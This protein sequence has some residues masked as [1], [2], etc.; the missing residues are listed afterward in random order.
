M[1]QTGKPTSPSTPAASFFCLRAQLPLLTPGG[2]IVNA[3]SVFGQIGSPGV[4]AYCASKAAVI[5][6]SR[7]AAKE[8]PSV[9]INCVAPGSVNT[10]MNQGEDPEDVRRGLEKTVMKRSAGAEEVARIIAVLLSEES[11]FVTGA[12]WNVDG[13]WVC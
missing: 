5:A 2:A 8:N 6:L 1:T 10:P 13:G 3:A 7:T 9:R 11:S 12:V 4:A